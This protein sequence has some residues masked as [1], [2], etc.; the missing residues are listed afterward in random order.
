[1]SILEVKTDQ[2]QKPLVD[3][4][5]TLIVFIVLPI[6]TLYFS[7]FE[8]TVNCQITIGRKLV[9]LHDV[10]PMKDDPFP[11]QHLDGIHGWCRP[12]RN[13]VDDIIIHNWCDQLF[14]LWIRLPL[15]IVE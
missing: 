2:V 6:D 14:L 13:C 9:Y 3:S 4:A 15:H 11:F 7:M 1:M 8:S 10:L 5:E 12:A